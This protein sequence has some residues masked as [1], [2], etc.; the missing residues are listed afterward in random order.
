MHIMGPSTFHSI[1]S[2]VC[3]HEMSRSMDK[4]PFATMKLHSSPGKRSHLS[5]KFISTM[6][7]HAPVRRSCLTGLVNPANGKSASAVKNWIER[8]ARI[9][10][11]AQKIDQKMA[12]PTLQHRRQVRASEKCP[13]KGIQNAILII[14]K[15]LSDIS[16]LAIRCG[17]IPRNIVCESF[18]EVNV[19]SNV[20]R[21]DRRW[22]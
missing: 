11:Y 16:T 21:S 2:F 1:A 5:V 15:L 8:Q 22:C 18:I 12:N 10:L 20:P 14:V 19:I 7:R 9:E 13:T 4:R 17:R 6:E 3:D